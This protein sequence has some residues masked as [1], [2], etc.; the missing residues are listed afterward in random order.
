[1]TLSGNYV[2]ANPPD[3]VLVAPVAAVERVGVLEAR[4]ATLETALRALAETAAQAVTEP[5]RF[6]ENDFHIQQRLGQAV[7][8]ARIALSGGAR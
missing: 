6:H 8:R 5:R 7:A 3:P 2:G 4:V 1:M